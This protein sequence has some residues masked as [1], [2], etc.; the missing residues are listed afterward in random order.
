MNFM[1]NNDNDGGKVVTAVIGGRSLNRTVM[2]ADRAGN[3]WQLMED[4]QQLEP[5]NEEKKLKS[6]QYWRVIG[7]SPK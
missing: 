7:R 5:D 1:D 3:W 2:T 6:Q 4:K